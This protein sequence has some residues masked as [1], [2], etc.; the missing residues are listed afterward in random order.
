MSSQDQSKDH[1]KPVITDPDTGTGFKTPEAAGRY[2][3]TRGWSADTHSIVKYQ[4]D[5]YALEPKEVPQAEKPETPPEPVAQADDG[6]EY[7]EVEFLQRSSPNE[8]PHVPIML[9]GQ[10]F[11]IQRG[12]P[13]VLPRSLLEICD[14]AS[15]TQWD[16]S[17]TDKSMPAVA[18]GTMLRYP[19]RKGRRATKAEF[20]DMLSKG[21][22]IKNAYMEQMRRRAS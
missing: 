4:P 7:Y 21:N 18:V 10:H 15:F 5:G 16:T 8:N 1:I 13:V 22:S 2:R 12:K 9:N 6:E 20:L 14:H 3:K 11:T 19:Y 17:G